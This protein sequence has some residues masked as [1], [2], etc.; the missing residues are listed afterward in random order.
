MPSGFK[1]RPKRQVYY[2][3]YVKIRRLSSDISAE[4]AE[5]QRKKAAAKKDLE[6]NL[7]GAERNAHVVSL[8]G[9]DL[10]QFLGKLVGKQER[11]ASWRKYNANY[12]NVGLIRPGYRNEPVGRIPLI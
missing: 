8:L 4:T 11:T 5:K 10:K 2:L 7:R 9:K 3:L 6:K 1:D 12:A